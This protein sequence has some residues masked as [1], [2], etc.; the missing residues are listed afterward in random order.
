MDRVKEKENF[1]KKPSEDDKFEEQI[2]ID[3]LNDEPYQY[4]KT[5]KP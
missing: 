3:V 2:V 4:I 1:D 5:D